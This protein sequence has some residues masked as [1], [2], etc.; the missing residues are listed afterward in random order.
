M[1]KY[2][3]MCMVGLTQRQPQRAYDR[4]LKSRGTRKKGK[5]RGRE[6]ERE[7][8]REKRKRGERSPSIVQNI[9][10]SEK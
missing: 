5:E 1:A 6:N 3:S 10:A 9:S 4:I 2:D 8:R 7:G